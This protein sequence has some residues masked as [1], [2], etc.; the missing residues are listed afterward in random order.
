M[1]V[2]DD[3]RLGAGAGSDRR[4]RPQQPQPL[5]V[6]RRVGPQGLGD[7]V[8]V[9]DQPD[10]WHR[11]E[12]LEMSA[13]GDAGAGGRVGGG[14]LGLHPLARG[15][16]DRWQRELAPEPTGRVEQRVEQEPGP[17]R[18]VLTVRLG[19]TPLGGRLALE[20]VD[21]AA[22]L[23][24][25]AVTGGQLLLGAGE[26]RAGLGQGLVQPRAGLAGRGPG[27]AELASQGGV[28]GL[29]VVEAGLAVGTH[30]TDLVLGRGELAAQPGHL[31]VDRRH[32][33]GVQPVEG[34][35]ERDLPAVGADEPD[36][37]GRLG[38]V[39]GQ[40]D[41]VG[42]L[43]GGVGRA[44]LAPDLLPDLLVAL[45]HR[46]DHRA[47]GLGAP[48]GREVGDPLEGGR[49]AHDVGK[50][51]GRERD[52]APPDRVGER[53]VRGDLHVPSVGTRSAI[54]ASNTALRW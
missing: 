10:P 49:E 18:G 52:D 1:G 38:R 28:V 29:E 35:L 11:Q 24:Q 31:G 50:H 44:Q 40:H 34:L 14:E 4:D 25:L 45:E 27:L 36:D 47:T 20:L 2:E 5:G 32:R 54:A 39:L 41:V 17:Q 48:G 23:A 33:G 21:L 16:G 12:L 30:L 46:G 43:L 26:R 37:G 8:A 53:R 15:A 6:E 7:V 9:H 13:A 22:E 3:G 42:G 51:P 19:C